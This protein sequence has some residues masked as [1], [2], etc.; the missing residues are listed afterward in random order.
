MLLYSLI[1]Q[2]D[3]QLWPSQGIFSMI[4][5]TAYN[6]NF[7]IQKVCIVHPIQDDVNHWNFSGPFFRLAQRASPA[8]FVIYLFLKHLEFVELT[9]YNIT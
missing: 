1:V 4:Q 2:A 9:L 8:R 3:V 6:I 5:W 7:A